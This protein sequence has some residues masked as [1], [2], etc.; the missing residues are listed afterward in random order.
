MDNLPKSIRDIIDLVGVAPAMALV[1]AWPGLILKVP[2]G[3][4]DDGITKAKLV[5]LMGLEAAQ[6]FIGAY[7]GEIL[8]VPR[9]VDALRDERDLKII[10]AYDSGT[11]AWKLALS[12]CLTERQVRNILKRQPGNAVDGLGVAPVVDDRQI[13][14]F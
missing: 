2:T 10:A 8:M 3:Q 4:K 11:P 1:S 5:S 7:G 6:K 13:G 14:L 12:N 9:C